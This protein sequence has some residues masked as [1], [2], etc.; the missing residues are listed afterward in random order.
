MKLLCLLALLLLL[1]TVASRAQS[2][3]S[4]TLAWDPSPTTNTPITYKLYQGT[5]T[6]VYTLT[7]NV[8]TNLTA[9]ATNLVRGTTYFWAVTA[10]LTVDTNIVLESV[11]SGEVSYQPLI[12]PSPPTLLRIVVGN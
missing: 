10:N 6:G 3:S 5:A 8:G 11:F 7:N 4:V 9:T 1:S 12:P 2:T